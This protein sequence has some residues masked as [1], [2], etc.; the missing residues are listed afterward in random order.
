MR[1]AAEK[2]NC[3]IA[4]AVYGEYSY[5]VFVLRDFRD[6]TLRNSFF[7]RAFISGYYALSPGIA[8]IA[9]KNKSLKNF[10][11]WLIRGF[12]RIIGKY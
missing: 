6:N 12:L 10:L 3:F 1:D 5:E 11:R 8:R 9:K 2:P 4:G 7:G